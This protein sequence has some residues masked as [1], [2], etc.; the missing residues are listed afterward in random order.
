MAY[1][2]TSA[3]VAL[4]VDERSAQEVVDWF[5]GTTDE[6]VWISRWTVTELASALSLKVRTRQITDELG[7][8][9]WNAFS[10][11]VRPSLQLSPVLDEDFEAAA[12]LLHRL[13]LGLRAGDALHVAIAL[14]LRQPVLTLDVRMRAAVVALGLGSANIR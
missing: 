13:D 5:S 4:L 9:A 11:L 1:L 12:R 7:R 14:R 10:D 2:D 6:H 3:L 8:E